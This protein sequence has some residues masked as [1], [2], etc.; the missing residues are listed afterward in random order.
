M[1]KPFITAAGEGNMEFIA[2]QAAL[3][4][5]GYDVIIFDYQDICRL[6]VSS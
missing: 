1:S 5:A 2:A 4:G 3:D 6:H